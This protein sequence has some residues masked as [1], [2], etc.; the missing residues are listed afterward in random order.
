MN[1]TV[2]GGNDAFSEDN[3][4]FLIE[5]SPLSIEP[6][7]TIKILF[8]CGCNTFNYY[9][10]NLKD[11]DYVFI[12]HTHFSHIG[13]LE[14][15]I[16]YRYYMQGGKTT[17]IIA[18]DEVKK[19]LEIILKDCN[20][21]YKDNK[22]INTK[23]FEIV[24]EI[25]IPTYDIELIKGNHIVKSNY[26]LLIK[27][28]PED[29]NFGIPTALFIS[30]DTKASENI[31]NKLQNLLD[32]GFNLTVFHDLSFRD[33]ESNNIHCCPTDFKRVYSS[34]FINQNIRLYNYHNEGFNLNYKNK[35]FKIF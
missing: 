20:K 2:I 17:R 18:G 33:D 31:K 27:D 4:S 30:G 26:G 11:I 10:N 35:K 8:D 21:S 6:A 13:G 24:T 22:I 9:K 16:F 28:K 14:R 25:D 23:L 19:E 5:T 34:L 15:L 7:T 29:L 1:I 12:S 3:S 32:K